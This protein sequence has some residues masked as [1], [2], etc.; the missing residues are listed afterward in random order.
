MTLKPVHTHDGTDRAY[1]ISVLERIARPVLEA[2]AARTLKAQMPAE[3]PE[4][5]VFRAFQETESLKRP[6][7]RLGIHWLAQKFVACAGDVNSGNGLRQWFR[8]MQID[9]VGHATSV[10]SPAYQTDPEDTEIVRLVAGPTN[11][12]SI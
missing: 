12:G 7:H 9:I 3:Q 4:R 5:R 2:G 11:H 6:R 10:T 1:W 8:P